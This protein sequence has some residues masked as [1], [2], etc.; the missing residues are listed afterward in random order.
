MFLYLPKLWSLSGNTFDST[1]TTLRK[2]IMSIYARALIH[3]LNGIDL[4]KL[5]TEVCRVATEAKLT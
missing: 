2:A 3:T 1:G 4:I 5:G